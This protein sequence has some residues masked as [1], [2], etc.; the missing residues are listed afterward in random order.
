VL[1]DPDCRFEILG[2]YM[3]T[4]LREIGM[5]ESGD[6]I[7]TIVTE[8]DRQLSRETWPQPVAGCRSF[9]LLIKMFAGPYEDIRGYGLA[10]QPP[11]I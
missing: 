3:G 1:V 11:K 9:L 10:S 7:F 2:I 4:T 8:R 5:P 6:A